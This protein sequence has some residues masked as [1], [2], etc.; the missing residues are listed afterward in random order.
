MIKISGSVGEGGEN[1]EDDV[2]AVRRLLKRHQRWTGQCISDTEKK[3][4]DANMIKAITMFQEKACAL[5]KQDG[6]VDPNGFTLK[7][8]NMATIAGPKHRVFDYAAKDRAGAKAISEKAFKAATKKLGCEVAAI[9]AVAEVEAKGDAWF[10]GGKPK[11]LFE[12]HYFRRFTKS[13][14]NKTHPDISGSQGGYGKFSAQYPKLKRAAM[15]DET[16]ALKSASWGMFQIMGSNYQAAGFSSVEGFVTSINGG[17]D[18]HLEAF[19]AF[20]AA[21]ATLKKAIQDKK[22]ATFAKGYNG[23]G[24]AKNAYDTKMEAASFAYFL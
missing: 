14:Y 13:Q 24:Y 7:R 19:V 18:A 16:A 21:N 6:R 8:L 20:V 5:L 10:S 1:C 9:K 15:L 23:P 12:R 22:W 2:V 11:I 17:I 4:V 3:T